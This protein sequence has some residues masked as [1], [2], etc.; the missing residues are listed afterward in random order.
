MGSEVVPDVE[1]G[2]TALFMARTEQWE[3]VRLA[4]L[5]Y[6]VGL[7]S[8]WGCAKREYA[9]RKDGERPEQE[10]EGWVPYTRGSG[11]GAV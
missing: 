2:Y 9:P 11:T 6:A 5:R 3:E 8:T 1:G 4:D 10:E 7:L